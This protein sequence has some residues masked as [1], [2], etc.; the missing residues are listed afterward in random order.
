MLFVCLFLVLKNLKS[1]ESV[2]QVSLRGFITKESVLYL[3]LSNICIISGYLILD[4]T[5]SAHLNP[6]KMFT[7]V[8]FFYFGLNFCRTV[9]GEVVVWPCVI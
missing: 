2:R 7:Q 3:C 5:R 1:L 6:P 8:V 9:V 4:W